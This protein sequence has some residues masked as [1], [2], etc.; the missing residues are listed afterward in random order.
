MASTPASTPLKAFEYCVRG[1]R[2]PDFLID[3]LAAEAE[4]EPGTR[5]LFQELI[6]PLSDSF[7]PRFAEAYLDTFA[8]LLERVVPALKADRLLARHRL[9]SR[10]VD[11]S[12]SAS[13][14]CLAS[15]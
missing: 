7:E 15:R 1:Q 9:L 10:P 2:V 4:S 8:R 11:K 14:S 3:S 6:E 5:A 12:P 13:S